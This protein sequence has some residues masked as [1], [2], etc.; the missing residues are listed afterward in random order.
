MA[1]TFPSTFTVLSI[2][3][4]RVLGSLLAQDSPCQPS[5]PPSLALRHSFDFGPSFAPSLRLFGTRSIDSRLSLPPYPGISRTLSLVVFVFWLVP[6]F[7]QNVGE[8]TSRSTLMGSS[9]PFGVKHWQVCLRSSSEMMYAVE[10]VSYPKTSPAENAPEA[11]ARALL[12]IVSKDGLTKLVFK[13]NV[14]FVKGLIEA[15]KSDPA[16]HRGVKDLIADDAFWHLVDGHSALGP[17]I[18]QL[19]SSAGSYTADLEAALEH[20][21]NAIKVWQKMDPSSKVLYLHETMKSCQT[22]GTLAKELED[23]F[24]DVN[25]IISEHDVLATCSYLAAELSVQETKMLLEKVKSIE[26]LKKTGNA[27]D[28]C[29]RS[30]LRGV[31]WHKL[32]K[33]EALLDEFVMVEEDADGEFELEEEK[34]ELVEL[35]DSSPGRARKRRRS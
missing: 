6:P 21:K 20:I 5:S 28:A 4:F 7:L 17:N 13:V 26:S 33:A 35:P 23:G 34:Y 11:G 24:M 16:K 1:R 32:D 27:N 2:T 10:L 12:N 30:W 14:T 9:A 19:D 29:I 3:S 31:G 22:I 18:V 25:A 8:C 15:V